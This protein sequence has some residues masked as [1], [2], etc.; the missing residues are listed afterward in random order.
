MAKKPAYLI[1]LETDLLTGDDETNTYEL[2][3]VKEQPPY[4]FIRNPYI[5]GNFFPADPQT[6]I[7]A[8]DV[9]NALVCADD[10]MRLSST[11]RSLVNRVKDETVFIDAAKQVIA[12][13]VPVDPK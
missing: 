6:L 11:L 8:V 12:E 13:C 4:R 3:L 1:S 10:M 2:Q 5:T 9:L 7:E